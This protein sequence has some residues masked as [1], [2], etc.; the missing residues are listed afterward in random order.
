LRTAPNGQAGTQT[1][2]ARQRSKS[3]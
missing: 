1:W 3:R 2:Q